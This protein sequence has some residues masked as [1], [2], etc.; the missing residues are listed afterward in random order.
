[1][2]CKANHV[3][4]IDL[5]Q[6]VDHSALAI[7]EKLVHAVEAPFGGGDDEGYTYEE[8]FRI[9]YLKQWPIGTLPKTVIVEIADMIHL[10]QD[11]L[12][13]ATIAYEATG[14]GASWASL[15]REKHRAGA[16]TNLQP[17]GY[18]ITGEQT[19]SHGTSVSKKDLMSKIQRLLAEGRLEL[20]PDLHLADRFAR[21]LAAISAKPTASG[22]LTF[23]APQ[24][25]HDDIVTAVALALHCKSGAPPRY[26]GT[27]RAP[28]LDPLAV[29][30]SSNPPSP[31]GMQ[32]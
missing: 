18:T 11:N 12:E 17:K 6:H 19:P 7:V 28:D 9:V 14:I 24:A 25:V 27:E 5:A 29:G 15:F 32:A 10:A 4:G 16:L 23:N 30:A 3:V 8:I 21:E 31:A 13:W 20:D 2:E 26:Y 22:R 1:M